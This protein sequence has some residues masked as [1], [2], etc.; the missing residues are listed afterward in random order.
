MKL[1]SLTFLVSKEYPT[2]HANKRAFQWQLFYPTPYFWEVT[3]PSWTDGER[4]P[5]GCSAEWRHYIFVGWCICH[6]DIVCKIWLVQTFTCRW[7]SQVFNLCAFQGT[8]HSCILYIHSCISSKP[9][10]LHPMQ[11]LCQQMSPNWIALIS[12]FAGLIAFLGAGLRR[13]RSLNGCC[14]HSPQK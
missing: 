6:W 7:N 10:L 5:V 4:K 8:L 1:V 13:Y 14:V 2:N 9:F 11:K 3:T 12:K